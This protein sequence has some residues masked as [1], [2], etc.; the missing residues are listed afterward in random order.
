MK[1]KYGCGCQPNCANSNCGPSACPG[2]MCGPTGLGGSCPANQNC[3]SDDYG[4]NY[5]C[6]ADCRGRQCGG[7]GCGGFCGSCPMGSECSRNQQCV[8]IGASASPAP[9]VQTTT[10]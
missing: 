4:N 9:P 3:V 1:S 2:I 5:C 10:K 6:T 7:D 8:V